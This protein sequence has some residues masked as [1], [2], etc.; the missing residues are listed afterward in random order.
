MLSQELKNLGLS[1]KE[2]KV[3]LAALELGSASIMEIAKQAHL[4]RPTTYVIMDA[5]IKRGLAS[6]F[7]KGKKRYFS[8]ESP[9]RL[10]SLLRLKEK[11]AQE[12]EREFKNILPEL[13]KIYEMAGEA[14]KV[15]FF[16]GKKGIEAIQEDILRTKIDIFREFTSLDDAYKYFPPTPADHR[17][18]LAQRVK[19]ARMIYTSKKGPVLSPKQGPFKRRFVSPKQFPFTCDIAVYANKLALVAYKGNLV[20]V[21]VEEPTI[22]QTMK[23]IFE[24]AWLGAQQLR[25]S[26]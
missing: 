20:G 23:R 4:N 17:Q 12:Q 19:E 6:S 5:L 21:V 26:N 15:R 3:Y 22:S 18:K 2:A 9:D 7:H 10:L 1:D 8:A 24:L 11:E 13:K 16:E 14:P 25:R